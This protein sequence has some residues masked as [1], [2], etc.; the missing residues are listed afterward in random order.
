MLLD[1]NDTR[2]DIRDLKNK[3]PLSL[4]LS[5]GHDKIAS[6]ISERA[7][8]IS[9]T[10]DPGSEEDSIEEMQLEDDHPN[11]NTADPSVEPTSPPEDS[12]VP[13][14]VPDCECSFPDSTDSIIPSTELSYP[15][16]PPSPRPLNSRYSRGQTTTDPNDTSSMVS[17]VANQH[18]IIATF[19]CIFAILLYV[20]PFSLPG[21]FSLP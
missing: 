18:F 12:H 2:I 15:P 17:I 16:Q 13:G 8:S 10:A 3:T 9:D 5:K 14:G 21:I 4:A 11:T 20:L 1:R 19:V 7:A 6:M